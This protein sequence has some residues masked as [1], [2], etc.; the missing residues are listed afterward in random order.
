M[1]SYDDWVLLFVYSCSILAVVPLLPRR[2][3]LCVVFLILYCLCWYL[4]ISIS[5]LLH[6]FFFIFIQ[7][8]SLYSLVSPF[9]SLH[10]VY[11]SSELCG[12]FGCYSYA[13]GQ[14]FSTTLFGVYRVT[15]GLAIYAAAS[16]CWWSDSRARVRRF[17]RKE[18]NGHHCGVLLVSLWIVFV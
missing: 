2:R 18:K 11:Q 6:F 8:S 4:V 17:Q 12:R 9:I 16:A 13:A 14:W 3:S 5:P 7:S 10:F 15:S 1:I